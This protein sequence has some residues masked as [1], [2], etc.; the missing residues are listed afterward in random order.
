KN[1]KFKGV[2]LSMET[3]IRKGKTL[4]DSAKNYPRIFSN[5]FV[6]MV[7]AGEESGKL[8]ESLT[9]VG[10]QLESSYKLKKKVKGAMIYPSVILAVMITIGVL[11][12][13]YVVPGI[14]ATFKDLNVKLPAMTNI[15][16]ASSDFLKN[17]IL[18]SLIIVVA[19]GVGYYLFSISKFGKRVIDNIILKLPVVGDL[20][21]EVNSARISRTISSLLSSGVPFAEAIKITSD[22]V[23][24]SYFKDLLNE[25]KIQ[26]EK[27]EPISGVFLKKEKLSPVFVGEMMNVGEETGRLP[28]M[29]LEVALFYENS[30]DQKTKDM[31]TIVEPVL[32][33]IIGLAV[34]FFALSMITPIYSLMDTI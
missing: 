9:I 5:L 1:A 31:S 24:N 32:M 17:N 22:V 7:R 33:V 26:V 12:L 25:A 18:L 15:L 20:S 21:R 6:S 2:I 34:G 4:S 11:M 19:I 10:N 13:I 27:G 8:A 3:D 30:V 14:T 23:Q 16:I 28:S 29:L